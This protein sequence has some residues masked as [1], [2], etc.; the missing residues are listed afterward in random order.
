MNKLG[1]SL[2]GSFLVVGALALS[3]CGTDT[4][5]SASGNPAVFGNPGTGPGTGPGPVPGPTGT[6]VQ[7]LAS[8]PQ[9]P[10]SGT[11]TVDLT[12]IVVDG[13]GQAVSGT[14]VVLSTGTDPSAYISNISGSGVSDTQGTVTAKLNLGS[15][16]SN[17]FISVTATAQGATAA[18]GV[19][20]TGTA[21]TISGSSS[22]AFGAPTT[23]TFSLKDS[24]GVAL[25]GFK[26]TLASAG[27]NPISP[28][29]GTPHS[30]GPPVRPQTARETHPACR[31]HPL[32]QVP[33]PSPLP[34]RVARRPPASTLPSWPPPPAA[35]RPRLSPA[36]SR[37]SPV[38]RRF[39]WWCAMWLI[40]WTR[41]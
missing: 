36:R 24:A 27:G 40:I 39:R 38:G 12:A 13:N 25:P 11:T 7:L 29:P 28:A 22:I 10:S 2:I 33:P 37:P 15:N 6:R 16:K 32:P 20:V 35:S 4:G 14:A 5:T 31:F 34:A 18:T 21:I 9:M 41:M 26:M 17:R 1:A 30:A 8:S 3:S 23:L 19:D